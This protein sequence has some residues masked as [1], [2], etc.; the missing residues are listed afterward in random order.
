MDKSVLRDPSILTTFHITSFSDLKKYKFYYWFAFPVIPCDW[1]VVEPLD[2]V[3]KKDSDLISSALEEWTRDHLDNME[4]LGFF[5]LKQ[6]N[7]KWIIGSLDQYETFWG[8][9]KKY[10]GFHD[11]STIQDVP[12]WPL[13][14]FLVLLGTLGLND[15]SILCFRDHFHLKDTL[16][17]SSFWIHA[18]IATDLT[19]TDIS[20]LKITGWERNSSGKLQPK[21]SDLGS[22]ISPTKLADQAVDLNLKLMKWRLAPSLDLDSI[23]NNSCLLL[24]AGTLGSYIARS[25]LGWGVRK[26]TFV[27]NGTVSFSN[28]VRQSLYTFDDCLNGGAKKAIRAAES[29]KQIYPSVDSEGYEL[30]VPMLGHPLTNEEKQKEDY[31]RL[32]ELIESHDT[33]F[34]LMDSRESRWLP[35]VISSAKG[36]LVITVALGFD[37]F[38]VMR[39]GVS[40]PESTE[41]SPH[42]GCYFCNDVV[43]PID[44][45]SGQTLDQMCTVTRPG[46]SLIASSLAVEILASILQHPLKGLAPV[47]KDSQEN[48]DDSSNNPL[49]DIPHQLRGFLH[50]F[51]IM[52]I[53]GRSYEHCSACSAPITNAWKQDGWEFIKRAF[54]EEYLVE[55]LSG[56]REV[57]RRAEELALNAS[58]TESEDDEIV[59]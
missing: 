18:D 39:H 27:D 37:S 24:G 51:S 21:L 42:L 23:K 36:K 33:I 38:V 22:L 58:W 48:S 57:Q 11:P 31:D 29:L 8:N 25:L 1:S 56:L 40:S 53:W 50:N 46:V 14:N 13:R 45:I 32:V 34:L 49:S 41:H 15:I 17:V 54:N 16:N 44:S 19:K 20:S 43:A 3:T 9:G 55:E 30:A 59:V 26:I 35:T 5:L 47:S 4:I 6:E 2:L 28:P 7:D 10:V 12:G 52:K